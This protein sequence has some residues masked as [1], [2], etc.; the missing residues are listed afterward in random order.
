MPDFCEFC[1]INKIP[2]INKKYKKRSRMKSQPIHSPSI[3]K[4]SLLES[5]LLVSVKRSSLL[6]SISD[7]ALKEHSTKRRP[8]R[9]I[10]SG[11]TA[12][13]GNKTSLHRSTK[14]SARGHSIGGGQKQKTQMR[15]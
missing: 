3:P 11:R 6:I 2:R 1:E 7:R 14:R 12:N 15:V 8:L 9:L 5:T 4:N 13:S 10:E